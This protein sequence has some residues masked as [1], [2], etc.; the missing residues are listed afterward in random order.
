MKRYTKDHE[1]VELDGNTA[2]VGISDHAQGEL[3]DIVFVELP[4]E[5]D[6]V[7]KG[8][9]F[10]VIESVKAVA[11]V[12]APMDGK[13]TEGNAALEDEPQLLN[14]DAEATWIAKMEV[15]DTSPFDELMDEAAYAKYLEEQG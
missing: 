3:G 5:G 12:Y 8:D 4:G 1:W 10:V 11:N 13:V 6:G 14:S 15:T 9:S 2:L 7:D